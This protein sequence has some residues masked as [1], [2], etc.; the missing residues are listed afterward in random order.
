MKK[1]TKLVS[2]FAAVAGAA[3]L[4]ASP[5]FADTTPFVH[6]SSHAFQRTHTVT[7]TEWTIDSANNPI[8]GEKSVWTA[9]SGDSWYWPITR[10]GSISYITLQ[11]GDRQPQKITSAPACFRISS[12]GD[13][14]PA[15]GQCMPEGHEVVWGG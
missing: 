3:S 12:A 6:V 13:M 2:L 8:A 11:E 10:A 7:I 5:A 14:H 9:T 4:L 1:R 15:D